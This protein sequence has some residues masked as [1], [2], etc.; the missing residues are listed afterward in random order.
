MLDNEIHRT[1]GV[2]TVTRTVA[3]KGSIKAGLALNRSQDGRRELLDFAR[4]R[5]TE[6]L[7]ATVVPADSKK[8]DSEQRLLIQAIRPPGVLD[9]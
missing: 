9:S 1:S 2:G 8:G 5:R 3:K 7:D 6:P 4:D